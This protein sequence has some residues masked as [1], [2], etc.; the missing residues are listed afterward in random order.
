M[1][2]AGIQGSV[3]HEHD[4]DATLTEAVRAGLEGCGDDERHAVIR[5]FVGHVATHE[6]FEAVK[7][8]EGVKNLEYSRAVSVARR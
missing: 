8:V 4:F 2:P 5:V 6:T 1:F 3:Y 7:E